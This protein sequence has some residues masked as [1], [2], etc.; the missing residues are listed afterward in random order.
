M[1]SLVEAAFSAFSA[2]RDVSSPLFSLRSPTLS[3]TLAKCLAITNR[4]RRHDYDEVMGDFGTSL[5]SALIF[6]QGLKK[7]VK[8][9]RG[10]SIIDR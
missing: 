3:N 7:N 6:S 10:G 4:R 5:A 2:F 9:I 1:K 8:T